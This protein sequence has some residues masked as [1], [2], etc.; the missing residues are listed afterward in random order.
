MNTKGIIPSKYAKTLSPNT[1]D[2]ANSMPKNSV[3]IA[4]IKPY[5]VN[6]W[7]LFL[8]LL[9]SMYGYCK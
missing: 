8:N 3:S 5:N 9:K 7:L 4:G 6:M 2:M 1:E